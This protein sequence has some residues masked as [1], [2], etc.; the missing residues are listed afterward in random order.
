MLA[1]TPFNRNSVSKRGTN[2]VVD[3]YNIFDDFF[4][5]SFLMNRNLRNDSFKIDIKENENEYI[6]EA[7]LPG[8]NKEEVALD[9]CDEYLVIGV[10]KEEEV[11][12]EKNDYIHRERRRSSLARKI[13]LKDVE[14]DNIDASLENGILSVVVPKTTPKENKVSISIR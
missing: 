11:N 13:Y 14:V 12:E 6:V 3:F 9:Y 10:K 2:D 7:E 5:D 4:N 8:V 1:L